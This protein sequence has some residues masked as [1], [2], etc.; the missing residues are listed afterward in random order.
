MSALNK[1]V[2]GYRVVGLP[3]GKPRKWNFPAH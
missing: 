3:V 1:L 2:S